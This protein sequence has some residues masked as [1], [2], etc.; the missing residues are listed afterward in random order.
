MDEINKAAL[1]A[2][3]DQ[4]LADAAQA[5]IRRAKRLTEYAQR[6]ACDYAS[7]KGI[8]AAV[9]VRDHLSEAVITLV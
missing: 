9:P 1:D 4:E 3:T 7:E 2:M 6:R 8:E 5:S